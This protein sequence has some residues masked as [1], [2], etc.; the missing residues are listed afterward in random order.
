MTRRQLQTGGILVLS[1]TLLVSALA[2]IAIGMSR[3]KAYF[4][5]KIAEVAQTQSVK[6]VVNPPISILFKCES[7]TYAYQF[8]SETGKLAASFTF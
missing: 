8:D 7:K 6:P 5:S 1:V 3:S 4:D 2:M